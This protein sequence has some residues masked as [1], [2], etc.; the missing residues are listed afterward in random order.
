M[1]TK[2][3]V[4]I[5]HYGDRIK[6]PRWHDTALTV[7]KTALTAKFRQ[8]QNLKQLLLSTGNKKLAEAS[9]DKFWGCGK[10]LHDTDVLLNNKWVKGA[11]NT[12]GKL[13]I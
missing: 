13:K 4:M 5:K 11:K 6:L 9:I 12:L 3:P 1:M 2:D 8:N 7:L 10:D